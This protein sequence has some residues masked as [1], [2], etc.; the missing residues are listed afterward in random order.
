MRSRNVV[1]ERD[2]SDEDACTY[3]VIEASAS[4]GEGLPDDLERSLGLLIG[5]GRHAAI[6]IP[7]D[8]ACNEDLISDSDSARIAEDRLPWG[9]RRD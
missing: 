8:G 3:N 4:L 1:E 6:R 7:T 2:V 9:A 5:T